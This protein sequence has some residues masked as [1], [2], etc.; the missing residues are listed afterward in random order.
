MD[1]MDKLHI[2]YTPLDAKQIEAQYPFKDLPEDYNGFFQK[3]GG[4]I[5]LTATLKALFN[6][7]NDAGN[8]DLL[9]F[10]PVTNIQ[11]LNTGINNAETSEQLYTIEKLVITP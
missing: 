6:I 3:D 11:S 9:E 7:A 1:V 2:P 5:D 4:I 10:T 8:I